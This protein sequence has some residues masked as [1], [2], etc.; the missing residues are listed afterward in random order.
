MPDKRS[1]TSQSPP[2]KW[3]ETAQGAHHRC[4]ALSG[5]ARRFPARPRGSEAPTTFCRRATNGGKC[6]KVP[7]STLM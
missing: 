7:E 5:I 1:P 6:Q 2:F 3:F 4:P